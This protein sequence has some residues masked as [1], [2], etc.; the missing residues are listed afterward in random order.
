MRQH[1]KGLE[2]QYPKFVLATSVSTVSA[3]DNN[4]SDV[5]DSVNAVPALSETALEFCKSLKTALRCL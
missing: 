1:I 3:N 2:M 4:L 5:S